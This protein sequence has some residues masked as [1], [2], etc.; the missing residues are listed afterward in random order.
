MTSRIGRLLLSTAALLAAAFPTHAQVASHKLLGGPTGI[1]KSTTGDMLEGM[2]VQLISKKTAI[3]TTVYS[4]ADGRYEFPKLDPG[5]YTLRIALPRE[6]QP[7]AKEAVELKGSD[8]LE[9]ITL[10]RVSPLE[11]LPPSKE[12]AAQMTGSE[13]LLS[14]TGTGEEKRLLTLNCNW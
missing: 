13:W 10:K 5:T 14:L 8:K 9:D 11:L 1:V 6:Y 3:R 2:M 4:D 7:F 12:I